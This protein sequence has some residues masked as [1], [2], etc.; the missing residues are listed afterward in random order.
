MKII[1]FQ[2]LLNHCALYIFYKDSNSVNCGS[3]I[4]FILKTVI[5]IYL[6]IFQTC[7][8]ETA[9]LKLNSSLN[10]LKQ[11]KDASANKNDVIK[12]G[13]KT[14]NFSFPKLSVSKPTIEI[15]FQGNCY[16]FF[17]C[18]TEI[19]VFLSLGKS[20]LKIYI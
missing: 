11:I 2:D 1:I 20:T 5:L 13:L 6:Y 8:K 15:I 9:T 19:R 12:I 17:V 7:N 16:I 18:S 10:S 14:F 3:E 4:I